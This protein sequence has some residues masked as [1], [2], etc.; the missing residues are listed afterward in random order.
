MDDDESH[1]DKT[2]THVI[3][4]KGTLVSHYKIINKI[5]AGGMGEV[6]LAEDTKLKRQV[7][8]KF[9]PAHL[10]SNADMRTRFTREAQAAA[11]LDHPNIV[12]VFEV[13][14]FNGR[15]FFAMANIEGHSLKEVIKQGK[16]SSAEAV[17]YAKQICEGLHK[18]HSA[19]IFHR[20]IKPANI[21]IDQD[22][23]PR[24]LDFGLATLS[25]EEKLTKTGST[26]GTVGYMAPEQIEGKKA[27]H[28]ADLFS[29]GVILYEMLTGRRP[30]EGDNDAA[31]VRAI[32]DAAPEPRWNV[33]RLETTGG[34]R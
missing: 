15:P 31:I 3:L 10:A 30:F 8:L 34:I 4:S 7:A 28:R 29:L 2:R 24:I 12:P 1:D 14:E 17:D 20:D 32:T 27:D 26:L 19:G 25:G 22:N 33:G 16:L 21:I 5:G 11:K 9:M 18:A 6:Y 13:G 23:K